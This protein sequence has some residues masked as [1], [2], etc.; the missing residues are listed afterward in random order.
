MA[1]VVVPSIEMEPVQKMSYFG[2]SPA[3]HDFRRRQAEH[4]Q[5]D[6]R[7]QRDHGMPRTTWD[8]Q[9]IPGFDACVQAARPGEHGPLFRQRVETRDID[10][11]ERRSPVVLA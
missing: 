5:A 4:T 2:G 3:D 6:R 1:C 9:R 8:E 10:I 11:A 7:L